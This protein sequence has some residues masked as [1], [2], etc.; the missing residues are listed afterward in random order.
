MKKYTMKIDERP[1]LE[2]YG[3][4]IETSMKDAGQDCPALWG[5]FQSFMR[6]TAIGS[7]Y[8]VSVNANPVDNSFSYF[9]AMPFSVDTAQALNLQKIIIPCGLYASCRVENLNDLGS[10]YNY[11]IYYWHKQNKEYEFSKNFLSFECYEQN[12]S[13]DD[14]FTLYFAI[15]NK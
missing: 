5:Q 15:D 2:L 11:V 1:K 6:K 7:S 4:K 8:G 13:L 12:W 3:L 10:C 14:H 9:A